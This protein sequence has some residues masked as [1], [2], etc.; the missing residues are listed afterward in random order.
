MRR[1]RNRLPRCAARTRTPNSPV[2]SPAT[3]TPT[4]ATGRT[5][6]QV[7]RSRKGRRAHE[8]TPAGGFR[9]A[10]PAGALLDLRRR[11]PPQRCNALR[12]MQNL[13]WEPGEL[14]MRLSAALAGGVLAA[15]LAA[16]SQI[17]R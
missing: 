10:E 8:I 17:G 16:I 3:A 6:G 7:P 15:A 1:T 12:A 5:D 11:T 14:R 2:G 9:S 13:P 4:T